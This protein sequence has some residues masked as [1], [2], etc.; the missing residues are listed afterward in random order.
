MMAN[1]SDYGELH[2]ELWESSDLDEL[3]AQVP[4]PDV[5]ELDVALPAIHSAVE[6]AKVCYAD[7]DSAPARGPECRFRRAVTESEIS[8]VQNASV[9]VNTK[10]STNWEVNVWRNWSEY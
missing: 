3:F 6:S 1:I 5:P 9:P 10:K 4:L 8:A 2:D 7:P